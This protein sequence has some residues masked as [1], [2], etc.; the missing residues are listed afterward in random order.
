M[1]EYNLKIDDIFDYLVPS[2]FRVGDYEIIILQTPHGDVITI[3]IQ[4]D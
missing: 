3:R 1:K 4:Y 2:Y